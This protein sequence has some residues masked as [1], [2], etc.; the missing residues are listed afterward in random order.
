MRLSLLRAAS[1]TALLLLAAPSHA[2]PTT[3]PTDCIAARHT[4]ADLG[5]RHELR[6]EIAQLMACAAPTCPD[7]IRA[8]CAAHLEEVKSQMPSVV[9]SAKDASGAF[10]TDVKVEVD[11]EVLTSHLDGTPLIVDPGEHTFTF[12]MPGQGLV[13]KTWL[14][15]QTQKDRHESIEFPVPTGVTSVTPIAPTPSSQPAGSQGMSGRT[16][17]TLVGVG[18]AVVGVGLGT[19]FGIDALSKKSSA[20]SA[21]PG[22]TLCA[23][24]DGVN[25]WSSAQSAANISTLMFVVGGLGAL[26]AAI[27][28]FTPDPDAKSTQ[29]GL[30]PGMI[31][32]KGAW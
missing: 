27:F 21:C 12:E 28:W 26:E 10:V 4:A 25:K 18:V 2:D 9:I 8:D 14:I 16:I 23:T 13:V 15:Q 7:D 32:L 31:Q 17:A 30:A 11:G 1:T 19:A 20:Q 29:V 5:K 3:T 24:Q 6:G 22:A